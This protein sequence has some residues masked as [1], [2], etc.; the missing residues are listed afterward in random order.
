MTG[1]SPESEID[2]HDVLRRLNEIRSA[3]DISTRT[4][5][6]S[7]TI[8]LSSWSASVSLSPPAASTLAPLDVIAFLAAAA[9][10]AILPASS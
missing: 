1:A 5:R 9:F 2:M 8:S 10:E 3:H 7:R 4:H 6:D